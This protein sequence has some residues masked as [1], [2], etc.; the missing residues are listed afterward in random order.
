VGD[1]APYWLKD[2]DNDENTRIEAVLVY[3]SEELNMWLQVGQEA[4]NDQVKE[5]A[6]F[7][8]NQILPT[9]RAFFGREW[10]PGVDGDNRINI[11]HV[12]RIG[13]VGAAYFW[14]GDEYVTAVNPY[15]NQ[16]EMIYVSLSDAVI[17]SDAYNA[18]IA[19]EMQHLIHWTTDINEDAW[20]N[21]GFSELA[22]HVNGFDTRR[23]RSYVAQ[24]D[25][26]LNTLSH[27]PEVIGAH[28]GAASLFSIYFMDRFG[29][30]ATQALVGH[31]ANGID[32]FT[33]TLADLNANLSF[34]DLFADWLVASF[35]A[36]EGLQ[37]GIY[38]YQSLDLPAIQPMNI[39]QFPTR[40][41]TTVSQYGADYFRVRS[42][43]PLTALFTGTQQ[44]NLVDAA[45]HSGQYFWISSPAD[46]SDMSLT[47]EFDLTDVRS[48]TLTFWTWYEIEA[49]W[50]Y[51]YVALSAD[52]G[53]TWTTIETQSTTRDNPIGNSFGPGF[54]GISGDET[55][56][57]WVKEVADL[58]PFVGQPVLLRFQYVTDDAVHGQGFVI[59][60]IAVP[61]LDYFDD[62]ERG[63][64][65]WQAAGFARTG[66]ILPQYF[67]VQ[68]ILLRD[69][70]VEV[71]RLQL[72]ENQRGQWSIPLDEDNNEA[73][74][75]VSGSTPITRNPGEYTYEIHK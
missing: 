33:H 35:L 64:G 24:T 10:Q 43:E 11:L 49:G 12:R 15:S 48:A 26:Q 72:D 68:Q 74:L 60:D 19:H 36:G 7:I 71:T 9:N 18:T 52:D 25:I 13:G 54:T 3:R 53:K 32:G 8:E 45:P 2:L 65:G 20:L 62:A 14:S 4:G 5:A 42:N 16:R 17:G 37:Q 63:N 34:D 1:I 69:S 29:E 57:S 38:Q 46:E 58:T 31:S 28:Y 75:I 66:H 41:E 67:I 47:R 39:V 22:A 27:E 50:D 44:V 40:G 30:E 6:H 21:E 56:P 23:A 73:I 51:A 59:D 70:G 55:E 61:E